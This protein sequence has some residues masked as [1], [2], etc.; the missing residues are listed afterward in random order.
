MDVPQHEVKDIK[1]KVSAIE[2]FVCLPSEDDINGA[3]IKDVIR[4]TNQEMIREIFS[5]KNILKAAGI[6]G[7]IIV[8]S[9]QITSMLINLFS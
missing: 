3:N 1:R 2:R 8:G 4:E 6:F 7:G 9:L 5:F